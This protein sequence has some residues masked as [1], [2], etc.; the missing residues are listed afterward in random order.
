[1]AADGK[2][3][4][5][6][7]RGRASELAAVA[8]LICRAHVILARRYKT[9][10][11]EIDIVARRGSRIAFVEVKQRPT[12]ALCEAAVTAETRRRVRRAADLWLARNP[13]HQSLDIGFDTVFVTPWRLPIYLRDGL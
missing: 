12:R 8:A 13:R 11:G 4:R 1:M 9:P 2:R 10:V 3:K 7:Q 6:N 5:A